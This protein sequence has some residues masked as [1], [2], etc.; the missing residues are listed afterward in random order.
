M[1]A[2]D[3]RRP[4]WRQRNGNEFPCQAKPTGIGDTGSWTHR[5]AQLFLQDQVDGQALLL[6]NL[7]SVLD[8]WQLRLGE[9]V[10]L[11]RHIESIKLAFYMQFAFAE[12]RAGMG[13]EVQAS[14]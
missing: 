14:A 4:R 1:R 9:A 10:L 3:R 5:L 2:A 13:E 12:M 8:H 6:L 7:P 11:A